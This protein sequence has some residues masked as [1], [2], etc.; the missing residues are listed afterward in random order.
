[1]Y[2]AIL[3]EHRKSPDARLLQSPAAFANAAAL[4]ANILHRMKPEGTEFTGAIS[5]RLAE[6]L[7][8]L[9]PGANDFISEIRDDPHSFDVRDVKREL[10][11]LPPKDEENRK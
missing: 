11:H 9:A 5:E 1:M 4:V 6:A 3:P 10:G 2:D 8:I 7:A